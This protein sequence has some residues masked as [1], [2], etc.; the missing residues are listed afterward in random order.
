MILQCDR[1]TEHRH[2]PITGELVD[3]PAIAFHHHRRT[4]HQ[5]GHDLAQPLRTDSR[6]DVHGMHHIG[7]E[8]RDLLVLSG[9][10]AVSDG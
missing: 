8:D 5:P 10:I 9:G 6:R 3:G 4:I 1:R 2:H 7:E